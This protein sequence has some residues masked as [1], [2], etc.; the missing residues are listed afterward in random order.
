MKLL[1]DIDFSVLPGPFA[2]PEKLVGA[3]PSIA[4]D[5]EISKRDFHHAHMHLQGYQGYA[6]W[7]FK[8]VN[9]LK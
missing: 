4:P 5:I 8:T 9:L 7:L 6:A 3:F 1:A 2:S